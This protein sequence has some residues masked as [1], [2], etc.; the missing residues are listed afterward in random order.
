MSKFSGAQ[1]P[2]DFGEGIV[3]VSMYYIPLADS[4]KLLNMD[5][6]H[7]VFNR[8]TYYVKGNKILRK[9]TEN[10]PDD[11][12]SVKEKCDSII[13]KSTLKTALLHPTYL[14]DWNTQQTYTFYQHH[15]KLHVSEDSLKKLRTEMFYRMYLPDLNVVGNR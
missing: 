9:D 10:I 13:V 11:M 2:K 7:S 3:T 6:V 4:V 1:I 8:Y 5:T 14:I 12:I 15:G